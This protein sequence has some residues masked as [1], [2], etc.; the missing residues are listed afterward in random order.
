MQHSWSHSNA[1]CNH[2]YKKRIELRTQEQP[3]VAEHR[4]G[5][6][7]P[8]P[9]PP[10]TGSTYHRRLQPLYTEKYKVSCSGFLPTTK[11]MQH[12]CSH[13]NAICNHSFKK[14]IELVTHT[15]TTT[16]CRTQTRNQ[17]TAAAAHTR[18]L[19][20]LAAATLHGKIQGFVL[21]LPPHNTEHATFMQPSQCDLQPQLQETHRTTHTGTTTC[22]RT[23]RRNQTTAAAPAAHRRYFSSP[24][25]ATLHGKHK[26]SCS[27]FLPTTQSMQHS[28]SHPNAICKHSFKKR[29]ELR[30]QEQPLVAEHRGGTKRPQPPAAHTRYLSPP[31]A[32][33]LHSKIQ[34]FVLQLPPHNTEHATF[35]QPFQCDLQPQL[36]ELHRTTH[37]GT[38]TCCRTQRRN[39]TTA[40]APAA[41]MRYLSS[42]A[43]ATLHGKIQ[44]FLLRLP[45]HN[46]EH[47]TFMQPF[48]CDLQPQF[49]ET[50]R[51]THTGT[52]TCC[53][54]QTTNQ[55]TAAAPAAH[56]RYLSSPT[57][58][59]LHGKIKGFVLRP[60]P[61]N[62]EHA[63]F[64][65]PFQC[66]LQPQLQETHR[67]THTGTTTCCRTQRRNQ[68]TAAAPAAHTRYLSSPAAA[69]LHGKIQGFVLRLP[70]HNTEHATF[71]QPLQSILQHSLHPHFPFVPTSHHHHFPSSP[72]PFLTTSLRSPHPLSHH[73][74]SS[75]LPFVTTSHPHHFPS[76]PLP[77]VTTSLRHHFPL[78]PLPFVT[79]SLRHH[80]PY[81]PHFP[82]SP[83]PFVTT[84]LR[85]HFPSSP[86]PFVTT[87]LRHHFP[88]SPLPFV[89][90]SL[91]HH[92]P[93][94]PLPFVTTSLRHHFPSSPLPFGHYFPSSPLPLVT[95]S[96]RHHFP[97]SPP[98]LVTT[99]LPHHFPSSP[100]PLVT[101]SRPHHFPSS[102]LPIVSTLSHGFY[103]LLCDVPLF[104]NSFVMYCFVMYHPSSILLLCIALWCTT[105]HQ[106]FCYV[107]LCHV[108][109]FINSFVMYCCV[110]YH[111]SSMSVSQF[112]L[113]VT[114]KYCFPTS[115]DKM[116]SA[117]LFHPYTIDPRCCWSRGSLSKKVLQQK[118]NSVENLMFLAI[119]S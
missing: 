46:T 89:T 39:Q 116:S 103:V 60:P 67:T 11:P 98:P 24:A 51:T 75:P 93:S 88:S 99:S 77:F 95:A 114:R 16:C 73:F 22:C 106:F 80:F 19:S 7:R 55:T 26:V 101:T 27:G 21:R 44:G 109:P 81:S 30:T 100:L 13:S 34:G 108:P 3:L 17:M 119:L 35:M 78:S 117:S 87:S 8:Q 36:Q 48:Q 112:Y 86:L 62:T 52:T 63:T 10:H 14:R 85:H 45:P 74:P 23:Q 71:M 37:T 105:L 43:A 59:T 47:A 15:G 90:T 6:K 65:Q 4:G 68:T 61:H 94:S 104:I 82:S 96:L 1:I 69:T 33:T 70:P 5:T 113:S 118:T 84:S 53:R 31:A 32:A 64:M 58:A 66:D 29:I 54:T 111:P 102:P 20:S 91:P 115:F 79:T 76:S 40:A 28:C 83:R 18:Y 92:F 9:H 56:T 2:S 25:A 41:H 57:A 38:T 42:P 49:Q 50:H 72:L 12:S 97:S 110:T 107:L